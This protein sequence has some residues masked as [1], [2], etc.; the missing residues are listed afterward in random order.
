MPRRMQT[1][2]VSA[3]S[4]FDTEVVRKQAEVSELEGSMRQLKDYTDRMQHF[5][6][7][8]QGQIM[9]REQA[10]ASPQTKSLPHTSHP[11]PPSP[12]LSHPLPPSPTFSHPLPPSPTFSHPLP[13]SPTFSHLSLVCPMTTVSRT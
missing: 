6:T 4:S 1:R 9:T 5:T 11:L 12:T 2:L 7:Q 13:P 3:K 8:V 10:R